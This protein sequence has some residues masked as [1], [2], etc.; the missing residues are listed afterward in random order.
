MKQNKNSYGNILVISL[1]FLWAITANLLPVLIPHLKKACRLTVLESSFIDSAYWI[2]YF[3]VAIPAGLVMKRFGYQKAIITGLLLAATGSF[4]FYPAAES[5]S[6][7]FFLFALFV[8]ASG[9]TFLETSA[10]PF[11]TILGDPSTAVRRLNF[12]QAFNGLGAF[13]ASM[14]LS[15]FI[16]AKN[17]KS[18]QE[19]DL[20]SPAAMDNYYS[21]LFHRVKL[22][23]ILIG[24]VLVLVALLFMFT[25]FSNN[26]PVRQKTD[27]Q[28]RNLSDRT[29]LKWGI[30]TQF[31]YVGAQV[32]ISSFFILYATS[33]AGITAYDA[34]NYLGLLLL[35]FMLG[36]YFGSILMKYIRPARLLFIYGT[37]NIF[38]MSFI[39]CIGGKASIPAFIALEFFMSIMY[40]TIFSLAIRNLGEYTPTASSYLVMSIIGGAIFPPLLGYLSDLTGSIQLAYIVP[41]ICFIP[42]VYFGWRQIHKDLNTQTNL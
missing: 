28:V 39:I 6:F 38:L 40:P 15:K 1:F 14:F 23:Y 10:N 41:L 20:L 22:P 13:I 26:K 29:Q 24:M 12:A 3:A 32:C 27:H 19:L 8:M 4:L 35:G 30:V 34:T 33:V 31:F 37:I 9:M 36:R 42:V 21:L 18:Q 25:R 5:R 11:M 2:A 17:I 7:A 16:I